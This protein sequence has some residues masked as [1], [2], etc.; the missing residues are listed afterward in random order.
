MFSLEKILLLPKAGLVAISRLYVAALGAADQESG[1]DSTMPV[2]PSTGDNRRRLSNWL[3]KVAKRTVC[4]TAGPEL[5]LARTT[6]SRVSRRVL[7]G[8]MRRVLL[9]PACTGLGLK[10][11]V[12]PLGRGVANSRFTN[13]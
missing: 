3:D 12:P 8:W 2:A 13:P 4:S 11:Q 6:T 1:V 5:V 7:P 10:D 9:L